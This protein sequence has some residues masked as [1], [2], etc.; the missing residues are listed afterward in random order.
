M[1]LLKTLQKC[2]KNKDVTQSAKMQYLK[3]YVVEHY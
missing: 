2:L 1:I 3:D